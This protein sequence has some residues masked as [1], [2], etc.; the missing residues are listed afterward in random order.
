[1]IE[2][3]FPE[4]LTLADGVSVYGGYDA[5]WQRSPSNI[6]KLTGTSAASDAV[7]ATGIIEPTTVQLVTLE[8]SPPTSAG[9]NSYGLR[10]AGSP[11][12]V[13]DHVTIAAPG[14]AAARGANGAHGV[15]GIDGSTNDTGTGHGGVGGAG[16][17]GRSGGRGG[18]GGNGVAGETAGA[19]GLS[20]SPD[21]WGESGGAGGR[22]GVNASNP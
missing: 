21:A 8:P 5:S 11:G 19:Q 13:L 7:V 14:A 18:D 6:T 3:M 1:M 17:A 2:G 16:Q 15:D 12:P 9:A 22:V 10:G 4:T 20:T